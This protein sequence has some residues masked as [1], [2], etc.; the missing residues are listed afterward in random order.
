M[1]E[2]K[3]IISTQSKQSILLIK[4]VRKIFIWL[5]LLSPLLIS[6]ILWSVSLL[7]PPFHQY[8]IN[9]SIERENGTLADFT[10]VA[11]CRLKDSTNFISASLIASEYVETN[12]IPISL[13]DNKGNFKLRFSSRLGEIDAFKIKVIFPLSES[14]ESEIIQIKDFQESIIQQQF[15]YSNESGCNC[16]STTSSELVTTGF[17]YKKDIGSIKFPF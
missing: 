5:M 2:L 10:V 9:G 17:F 6:P 14:Y 16:Q 15:T 11:L 8:E 7:P 4:I 13:T 3:N 1:I 12:D